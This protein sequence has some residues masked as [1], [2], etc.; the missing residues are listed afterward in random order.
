MRDVN[1]RGL[2]TNGTTTIT[3][4]GD[5]LGKAGL[6]VT[7]A[8]RREADA[9][10]R[11]H[12]QTG[13]VRSRTQGHDAWAAPPAHSY[14]GWC[15]PTGRDRRGRD[16]AEAV[17]GE[18]RIAAGRA[19]RVAHR[20]DRAG[21]HLY[22]KSRT[23]THGRSCRASQ[24]IGGKLKPVVHL[25]SAKKLQLAWVWGT[26]ALNG[27]ARLSA[28]LPA[29]GDYTIALHDA[30]YAGAAP[31][32]FRLKIG[33][34]DYVEQVFPPVVTKETKSVE[35][36]GSSSTKIDLP[37]VRGPVIPLDWPKGGAWNGPRPFVELSSRQEFVGPTTPGKPVDLPAG[38]VGVSGK[39]SA[40][41]EED[42][43]RVAVVP[44]TK[45]RFEVFAER[46]GSPADAAIVIRNDAGAV[47]AQA[48][49]SPGTLDPALEFTVPDKIA[50]VVVSVVDSQGRGGPNGVYRL[51][52]DPVKAEGQSE[53]RLT[54]P[55][56]RLN[57]PAGGRAV[58]PVFVERRGFGGKIALAADT[59]A[60]RS[61][62]RRHDDSRRRRRHT[63]DHH[64]D[65]PCARGPHHLDRPRRSG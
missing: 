45:V 14:R 43:Y 65:R 7:A 27:D 49:D 57:L 35:L 28:T 3:V 5:D 10:T 54:T 6:E 59:L 19:A 31:G 20:R 40:P 13:G 60:R 51:V 34:F 38:R 25:Y 18:G 8:V 24:R 1:V 9:Q 32:L 48:E 44:N 42:K 11:Q 41:G 4:S 15:E 33:T 39:L 55:L 56:Q 63:R 2:Q 16:A 12:R 61:E 62:A 47:L 23:E 37:T 30:E 52:I 58:V 29:D 53:F 21:N 36:I 17:R 64:H 50:S 22:G 26:P 46:I